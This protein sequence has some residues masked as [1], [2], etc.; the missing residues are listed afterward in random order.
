MEHASR[1]SPTGSTTDRQQEE[2]GGARK[3]D[4]RARAL[5]QEEDMEH[6]SRRSPAAGRSLCTTH[7][8]SVAEAHTPLLHTT[9]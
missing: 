7:L 6:A 5:H 3:E 9:V 8:K 2:C 1:R 4:R